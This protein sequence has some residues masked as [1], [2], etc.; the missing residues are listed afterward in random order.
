[1]SDTELYED[2][3]IVVPEDHV[4]KEDL[5]SGRITK[6]FHVNLQATPRQLAENPE[7]AVVKVNPIIFDHLKYNIAV[8]NRSDA[9]EQDL[10]GN[11]RRAIPISAEVISQKNT[12]HHPVAIDTSMFL[13]T[14]AAADGMHT[15]VIDHNPSASVNNASICDPKNIISSSMLNDRNG[16]LSRS[17]VTDI[18]KLVFHTPIDSNIV[19][20]SVAE[21]AMEELVLEGIIPEESILEVTDRTIKVDREAADLVKSH[22]EEIS[23]DMKDNYVNLVDAEYVFSP[24]N[25]E[26]TDSNTHIGNTIGGAYTGNAATN[27][28]Y[29]QNTVQSAGAI[30]KIS[31]TL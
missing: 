3:N 1:M 4:T 13:P 10:L 22:L 20:D 16:G 19:R 5:P 9:A 24:V 30:V 11:P 28:D 23:Q 12:F 25:A 31:Y 7:L 6:L 14:M 26:W 21:D 2:V 17:N 27:A 15:W 18:G 8:S 29:Y